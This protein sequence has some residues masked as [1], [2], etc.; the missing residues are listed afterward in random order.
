MLKM[1]PVAQGLTDLLSSKQ[2]STIL[3]KT[4]RTLNQLQLAQHIS[5]SSRAFL[6]VC[7]TWKIL[8]FHSLCV[9]LQCKKCLFDQL[10]VFLFSIKYSLI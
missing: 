1:G 6:C 5:K 7:H 10:V 4:T 3:W 8:V 9:I 2:Y